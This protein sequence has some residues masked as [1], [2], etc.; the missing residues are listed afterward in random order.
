MKTITISLLFIFY[1]LETYG[2][3]K[4]DFI[5]VTDA[6]ESGRLAIEYNKWFKSESSKSTMYTKFFNKNPIGAKKA[7]E[8]AKEVC[9][10][11]D[12]KFEITDKDDSYLA[13]F[14]KSINDFENLDL[15]I[16]TGGS[17]VV[18]YWYKVSKSEVNSM[19]ILR[20]EED[21]YFVTI[22]YSK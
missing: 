8:L 13:S 11:N 22:Y 15:S 17:T 1:F 10:E 18:K 12:M 9:L 19:I 20:L 21:N 7:I 14:V 4:Y 6:P 3:I 2:Q 5:D 16:K